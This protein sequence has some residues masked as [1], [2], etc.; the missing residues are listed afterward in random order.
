MDKKN[1]DNWRPL[2]LTNADY[3]ILAKML[4]VRTQNVIDELIHTDQCGF[5]KGRD[6]SNLLREIDD[7][8]ENNKDGK[9]DYI[10]LAIDYRKAFDTIRTD[11]IM[12]CLDLFGFGTYFKQWIHIILS[13]RTF[14]VKNGGHLSKNYE[15]ERGA[16]QGCPLSPLLF[17]LGIEMLGISIRQS[18]NI[19]GITVRFRGHLITHK[20]KQY[21]DDTTFLLNGIIDFREVLSKIKDFSIISGLHINK[22]KTFAMQIGKNTEKKTNFEGIKF[23]NKIKLLGIHFSNSNSARN[24]EDNWVNRI[25]KLEKNL[26]LWSR[27][28]LTLHGK[29]LIIKTFGISQFIYVMKSIGLKIEVLKKINRI[30]FSFIWGKDFKS[31]RTFEKIKRKTLCRDIENGGLNMIDLI[32][33]QNTFLLKWGMKLITQSNKNWTAIPILFLRNVGWENVFF[34][35]INE[36]QFNGLESIKSDFWKDVIKNW[37]HLNQDNK[38]LDINTLRFEDNT[39]YNNEEIKF[40]GKTL[41]LEDAAI[42]GIGSVRDMLDSGNFISYEEFIYKTGLYPR[43]ELDYNVIINALRQ[44]KIPKIGKDRSLL[45]ENA[46]EILG[47]SNKIL[48]NSIKEDDNSLSIGH[49]FWNRKFE[50]DI[51]NKFAA[52]TESTK[53]IKLREFI[54]KI[55]HNIY[56][57]NIMLQKMKISPTDRCDYCGEIDYID[58]AFVTC[59]KHVD[60]WSAVNNWIKKEIGIFIPDRTT[61]KLFGIV[62]GEHKNYKGKKVEIANHILLIA[63]FSIAKAKFYENLRAIDIFESEILKRKKFLTL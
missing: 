34:S 41:Y 5:V 19:K 36:K 27:R 61:E 58:H 52:T 3:K 6:I 30:L 43:A 23:T 47:R 63:K 13:N 38:F 42:R 55:F 32:D 9:N 18:E 7:I 39:I 46:R 8:L 48:R 12:K 26:T 50:Q 59:I 10:L 16:R 60:Y 20:I 35:R 31:G 44:S 1:L 29:V 56:P 62:K 24:I 54:F 15:M 49:Q 57:T 28:K 45:I 2:S 33:M 22:N 17:I 37:I 21:A 53:E 4:A 14:C 25:E 40:K 11:F 51:I